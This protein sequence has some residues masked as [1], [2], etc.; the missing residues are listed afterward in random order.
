M[1]G[2]YASE[3][4]PADEM[5]SLEF[6]HGWRDHIRKFLDTYIVP[7][8]SG[9][10]GLSYYKIQFFLLCFL[11]CEIYKTRPI[12]FSIDLVLEGIYF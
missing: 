2:L 5:V 11:E 4:V 9:G 12:D 6:E 1:R 8:H 10:S 7:W 3:C